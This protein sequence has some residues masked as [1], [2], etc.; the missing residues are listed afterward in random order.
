MAESAEQLWTGLELG[1]KAFGEE[2]ATEVTEITEA[3]HENRRLRGYFLV[4]P[5]RLLLRHQKVRRFSRLASVIS[6]TSVAK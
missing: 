4:L 5:I 3:R 1:L 2:F 6:V